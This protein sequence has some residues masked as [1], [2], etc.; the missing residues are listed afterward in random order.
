MSLPLYQIDAFAR[1]PFEGNPA[2]VCPLPHWPANEWL[3]AVAAE[4]NLSETAFF[5]R[6]AAGYHIRWFT[7]TCEVAL[8]GHAT[9]ASAYALWHFLGERSPV[10]R[11][12][13]LSG[14]LAVHRAGER[15]VLD[16]PARPLPAQ[17]PA[18]ALLAAL[19]LH[20]ALWFGAAAGCALVVVPD[21]AIV[22]DLTPDMPALSRCA[23]FQI[24]Y[25]T[26]AGVNEDF[27]CR[28]FAPAKG[29]NEDPVTGSAYTSLTPYWAEK[30]GRSTLR[31]RQV[32]RR[33]GEVFTELRGER[34]LIG[35]YAVC[36]FKGELLVELPD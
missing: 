24:V 11:F 18:P 26:A 32:S 25:V 29:I 35:G 5:V 14:E 1:R 36:V 27:V 19:G 28:V 6:D 22:T 10:L 33:G 7:P 13:S 3:Q 2:A 17:P 34:V 21:P 15:L 16:F 23:P 30:T 20:D 8:C 9:L 31:A 12:R 4:N